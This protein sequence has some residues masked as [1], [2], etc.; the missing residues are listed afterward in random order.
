MKSR[1]QVDQEMGWN[2]Q[3]KREGNPSRCGDGK[4]V[5]KEAKVG[6]SILHMI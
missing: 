1:W 6:G 2:F 3:K 5:L 4:V